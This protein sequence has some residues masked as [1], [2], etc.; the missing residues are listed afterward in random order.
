MVFVC[1]YEFGVFLEFLSVFALGSED[2]DYSV[3]SKTTAPELLETSCIV[4]ALVL[5]LNPLD[6]LFSFATS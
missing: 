5:C 4:H 2:L 6:E 1:A 3:L